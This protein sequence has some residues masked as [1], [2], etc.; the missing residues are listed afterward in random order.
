MTTSSSRLIW[1]CVH[2][3]GL[4]LDLYGKA[5]L[6]K[7]W[8]ETCVKNAYPVTDTQDDKPMRF[9]PNVLVDESGWLHPATEIGQGKPY[10]PPPSYDAEIGRLSPSNDKR[11]RPFTREQATS[12]DEN[13]LLMS[14]ID[15]GIP[16]RPHSL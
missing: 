3:G 1:L 14:D 13:E 5:K 12:P 16:H 10:V 11:L 15:K 2:C 6:S 8:D 7:H 9:A 4:S